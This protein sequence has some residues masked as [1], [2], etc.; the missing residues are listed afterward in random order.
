MMDRPIIEFLNPETLEFLWG[1]ADYTSLVWENKTCGFGSIAVHIPR[2]DTQITHGMIIHL[3]RDIPEA[4]GIITTVT[5]TNQETVVRASTLSRVFDWR[6]LQRDGFDT[7]LSSAEGTGRLICLCA[8]YG[9]SGDD[10]NQFFG[11][12]TVFSYPEENIH[13]S[14]NASLQTSCLE[15]MTSVAM[16][17]NYCFGCTVSGSQLKLFAYPYTDKGQTFNIADTTVSDLKYTSSC[18]SHRNVFAYSSGTD[19]QGY[20]YKT[21][22][23]GSDVSGTEKRMLY[24]GRYS[25]TPTAILREKAA[26]LNESESVEAKINLPYPES[27]ALGEI[28]TIKNP[29]WDFSKKLAVTSVREIWEDKYSCDV[30]FGFPQETVY[31]KMLRIYR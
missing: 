25:K 3:C 29:A 13:I 30:T 2:P 12:P 11:K 21:Y 7:T 10:D 23:H 1:C 5:V 16:E 9:L 19:D 31:R 20:Y 15:L 28:V 8:G 27:F 14:I 18:D 4:Y 26:L 24:I 17:G 6:Y 22:P